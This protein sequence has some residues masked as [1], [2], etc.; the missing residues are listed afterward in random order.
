MSDKIV[1]LYKKD[2][3]E[4]KN[5]NIDFAFEVFFT[6]FQLRGHALHCLWTFNWIICGTKLSRLILTILMSA[7]EDRAYPVIFLGFL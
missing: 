4:K 7:Y 5:N 1:S 3:V 2:F 6:L